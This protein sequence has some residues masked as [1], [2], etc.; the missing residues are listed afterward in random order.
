MRSVSSQNPDIAELWQVV[1]E[2]MDPL[3]RA[4]ERPL[5]VPTAIVTA[6]TAAKLGQA[7]LVN[8]PA[9]GVSITLPSAVAK[10]VG[11]SVMVKNIS[12]SA[13]AITLV[14]AGSDTIDGATS[15]SFSVAWGVR[16]LMIT[17]AGKW[18][19]IA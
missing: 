13:N 11:R 15:N 18:S 6:S 14:P 9:A 12:A 10:E 8:P 1:R 7:V 4:V 19:V 17:A 16:I 3:E 5:G 2:T